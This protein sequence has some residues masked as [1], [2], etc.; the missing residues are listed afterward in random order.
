MDSQ[1]GGCVPRLC[2]ATELGPYQQFGHKQH[3][4]IMV[5]KWLIFWEHSWICA[6]SPSLA[7]RLFCSHSLCSL[8]PP[9]PLSSRDHRVLETIVDVTAWHLLCK[10]RTSMWV[11]GGGGRLLLK[12]Q[13][14]AWGGQGLHGWALITFGNVVVE[15][16]SVGSPEKINNK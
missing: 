11:W 8:S 7:T 14:S 16:I 15:G 12:A 3:L 9:A 5:R 6:H 4:R 10:E 13:H 1:W 2:W